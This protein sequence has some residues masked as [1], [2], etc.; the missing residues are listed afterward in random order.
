MLTTPFHTLIRVDGGDASLFLQG[1]L[2]CDINQVSATPH[3]A[4][5]CNPKGRV[6]SLF[7]ISQKQQLFSLC[8]PTDLVRIAVPHLQKYSRLFRACTIEVTAVQEP[9]DQQQWRLQQIQQGIP[10]IYAASS[11]LFL[12]QDLNL[13]QLDA[14]SFNK[15]CYTGQEV[16]A[17]M[18]HLGKPKRHLYSMMLET[19]TVPAP[20]DSLSLPS[21]PLNAI[22]YI[23]DAVR[24]GSRVATTAVL[25]THAIRDKAHLPLLINQQ[26]VTAQ[27][28]HRGVA[29]FTAD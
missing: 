5:Q 18:H 6:I 28:L 15:G 13:P 14:V 12:P 26:Q 20:A 19:S 27:Q 29:H 22:G 11:G 7:W 9:L 16:I 21:A 2:T 10:V 23:V 24:V 4:A 3:L 1:Q 25:T 17:R 8:L